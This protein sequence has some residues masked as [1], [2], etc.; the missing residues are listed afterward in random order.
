MKFR[1]SFLREASQLLIWKNLKQPSSG[2]LS[3]SC[4]EDMQQMYRTRPMQKCD[5]PVNLMHIFRTPC[6]KNTSGRLLLKNDL[7]N[8]RPSPLLQCFIFL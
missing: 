2:V 1:K 6:P 4:P 8:L 7:I 3:K 5:S